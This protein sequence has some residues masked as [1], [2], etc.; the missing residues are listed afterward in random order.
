VS[1]EEG[2]SQ[3]SERRWQRWPR[4]A[5]GSPDS[6][7]STFVVSRNARARSRERTPLDFQ[8][9]QNIRKRNNIRNIS[10]PL[11][12][13]S[14]NKVSWRR[15]YDPWRV[16]RKVS[17]AKGSLNIRTGRSISK[18]RWSIFLLF[19]E[20]LAI[21]NGTSSS[22]GW[23]MVKSGRVSALESMCARCAAEIA[24]IGFNLR[25]APKNR[26][27]RPRYSIYR[28][29]RIKSRNTTLRPDPPAFHPIVYVARARYIRVRFVCKWH[30][31]DD[32]YLAQ[33]VRRAS[34]STLHKMRR[35]A[36]FEFGSSIKDSMAM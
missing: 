24:Q 31:N 27:A 8:R 35:A 13:K 14:D 6:Y 26:I 1:L 33:T 30:A 12:R 16:N 7:R 28:C 22:H 15:R 25:N 2:S 29:F 36:I 21:L 3:I 9:L 10:A 18:D 23:A 11:W 17:R 32:V 4:G 34:R 19:V 5:R 20:F